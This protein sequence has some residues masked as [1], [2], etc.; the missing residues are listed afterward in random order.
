MQIDVCEKCI[1]MKTEDHK[2]LKYKR[3]LYINK[4]M[5]VTEKTSQVPTR[6]SLK[7]FLSFTRSYEFHLSLII[8]EFFWI[9]SLKY[10][11]VDL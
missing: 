4:F 1:K 11:E 8:L 3:W 6:K 5:I 9:F 10:S 2:Y 7:K